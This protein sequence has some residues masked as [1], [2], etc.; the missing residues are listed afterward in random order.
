MLLVKDLVE[1]YNLKIWGGNTGLDNEILSFDLSRPGLEI[2]GYFSHYSSDRVQILGMT[3]ISFFERVLSE[4][5]REDR[6]KRLCRKE[7]PCIIVTRSQQPPL[8]LIEA[9]NQTNTVLLITE[10]NT[11]NFTSR[12][13]TYLEQ[14]AGHY[15]QTGGQHYAGAG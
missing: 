9:C 14:G 7:T 11:T 8:E 6:A 3:E 10:D 1:E 13:T 4:S 5:E 12:I 2:A 15:P